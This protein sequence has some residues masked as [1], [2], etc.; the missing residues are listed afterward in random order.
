M[1]IFLLSR[2]VSQVNCLG[3]WKFI[4]HISEMISAHTGAEF[5]QVSINHI[6]GEIPENVTVKNS[7]F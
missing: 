4:G 3:N 2:S 5:N 7:I 6:L 1:G